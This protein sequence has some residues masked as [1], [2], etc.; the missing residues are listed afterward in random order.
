MNKKYNEIQENFRKD[1]ME[2][3]MKYG[4]HYSINENY[5]DIS[6]YIFNGKYSIEDFEEIKFDECR[7]EE[8][9]EKHIEQINYWK[10]L[11]E[12]YKQDLDIVED[13]NMKTS[14]Q[15]KIL[16]CEATIK[17]LKSLYEIRY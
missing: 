6:L 15:N 10:E 4:V 8:E 16:L 3:C 7:M 12:K 1:Y 13:S 5:A 14:I 11:L 9:Y 2:L 17:N